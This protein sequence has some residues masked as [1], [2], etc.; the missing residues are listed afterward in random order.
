MGMEPVGMAS[1]MIIEIDIVT[2][3]KRYFCRVGITSIL[4]RMFKILHTKILIIRVGGFR[5]QHLITLHVVTCCL[6]PHTMEV[7]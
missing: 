6:Y 5:A 7:L 2:Q 4:M 3:N 1:A